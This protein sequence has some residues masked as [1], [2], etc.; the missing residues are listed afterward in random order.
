[1]FTQ[2]SVSARVILLVFPAI[3]GACAVLPDSAPAVSP[4]DVS[5][6][7][8]EKSF[9]SPQGEWPSDAWWVSWGDTELNA[10]VTEAFSNKPTLKEAA[11]RLAKAEASAQLAGAP[12]YP[13]LSLNGEIPWEKQ[14]RNGLMPAA[15]LPKEWRTYPQA[16]ANLS[17][18]LDLWGK[19]RAAFAAATS[20]VEAS[21]ADYAQARLELSSSVASAWAEMARLWSVR[22]TAESAQDIRHKT[23]QLMQKRYQQGLE[24][25]IAVQR[26]ESRLATARGDLAA[27]DE[28]ISLQ[29]DA[30]AALLG[31][32]PDRGLTILRPRLR[33]AHA[34][35]LP[36]QL[37]LNLLGRRPDIVAARLRVESTTSSIDKAEASF[38]PDVNL[39]ALIG[40]QSLSIESFTKSG[41]LYGSVGPALT[42]PIFDGGKL[43]GELRGAWADR[44][45]AVAQYDDTLTG[46]LRQVADAAVSLKALG[47]RLTAA[48]QANLAAEKAWQKMRNRY[49]GGLSTA[50][51]VLTAEDDML[52]SR[53]S[54]D[55]L[56]S[57]A[58]ALDAQLARALGGGW[59][60]TQSK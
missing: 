19:N 43:R 37:G 16:T 55:D 35:G 15:M 8:A 44:D 48:E 27:A 34:Q 1:M 45:L 59:Q 46:A 2:S 29:R 54:V 38:Y 58:F 3:L 40:F 36:P 6:Y 7:A 31:K 5:S 14:S 10:L 18:E 56:R 53:R 50:L 24:N 42:L 60:Q 41:S 33:L 12:E 52:S 47:G 30:L 20:E 22:D 11:A 28:Q 13:D 25:D 26:A 21:A 9:V 49:E 57:R 23:L 32:G 17:W 51:E 39:S 4:K